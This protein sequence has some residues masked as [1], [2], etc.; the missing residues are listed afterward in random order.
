[1]LVQT[2]DALAADVAALGQLNYTGGGGAD[3]VRA[4]YVRASDAEMKG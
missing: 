3:D 2:R 1:M 4:L